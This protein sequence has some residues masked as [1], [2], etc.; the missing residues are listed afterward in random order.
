[1]D[2]LTESNTQ[3]KAKQQNNLRFKTTP[4]RLQLWWLKLKRL[5]VGYFSWVL[6]SLLS[7]ASIWL[8]IYLASSVQYEP[9]IRMK[10]DSKVQ[11]LDFDSYSSVVYAP[12]KNV[13]L[14]VFTTWCGHCMDFIPKYMQLAEKLSYI[15]DLTFAAI[16]PRDMPPIARQL[17]IQSFPVFYLFL[18][19]QKQDPIRFYEQTQGKTMEEFLLQAL[20]LASDASL[21]TEGY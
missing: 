14:F 16:Q 11:V 21:L 9:Q 17:N 19:G 7:I 1:M 10:N 18:R 3:R 12:E 13:V 5:D 4:S 2:S 8:L 15:Q 6:M 20:G